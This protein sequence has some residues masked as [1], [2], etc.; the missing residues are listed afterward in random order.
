[1]TRGDIIPARMEAACGFGGA[2]IQFFLR[3]FSFTGKHGI[4]SLPDQLGNGN[5]ATAG[6]NL[7]SSGLIFR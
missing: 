2:F 7:D 5:S 4:D 1:M 3:P 6:Q